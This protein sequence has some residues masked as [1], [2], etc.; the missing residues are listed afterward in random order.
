MPNFAEF[1]EF[2]NFNRDQIEN[3]ENY[4]ITKQ[5]GN[6]LNRSR[7]EQFKHD[8][9]PWSSLLAKSLTTFKNDG[10]AKSGNTAVRQRCLKRGE[11]D[12]D[13]IKEL[14]M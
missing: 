4:E 13:G 11:R 12:K 9:N 1:R 3:S 6:V 7:T 8:I 5:V 14:A 10:V 2:V